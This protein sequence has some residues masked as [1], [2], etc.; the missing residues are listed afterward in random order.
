[1][2]RIC[3]ARLLELRYRQRISAVVFRVCA[4]KFHEHE[5]AR[6]IEC[7]DQAIV[8]SGNLK[9]DTFRVEDACLRERTDHVL[10]RTPF[11]RSGEQGPAVQRTFGLRCISPKRFRVL[12]AMIRITTDTMFPK[13]EQAETVR[14]GSGVRRGIAVSIWMSVAMSTTSAQ[15]ARPPAFVD[16][17]T[18][19]PNLAVE[20]RYHGPH[21]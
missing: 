4:Q 17:A 18:V 13:R 12:R 2:G 14:W 19:V 3:T 5:L 11:C 8:S 16:A 20:M 9:A 1:M 21:N 15:T 6:E 7:R 10:C